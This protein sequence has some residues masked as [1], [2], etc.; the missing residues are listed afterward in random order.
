M[1][2]LPLG[3]LASWITGGS[4]PSALRTARSG[5]SRPYLAWTG[6]S[7]T[8]CTGMATISHRPPWSVNCPWLSDG[9]PLP[10]NSLGANNRPANAGCV[11]LCLLPFTQM[12]LLSTVST[13]DNCSDGGWFFESLDAAIAQAKTLLDDETGVSITCIDS[14]DIV[15]QQL[16]PSIAGAL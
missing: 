6:V 5:S 11:S 8:S 3:S 13:D 4:L 14:Q 2:L 7:I 16:P 9:P 12:Y 1:A 10:Q 15:W